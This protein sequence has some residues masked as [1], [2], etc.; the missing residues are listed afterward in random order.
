MA[1]T[2]W[3]LDPAHTN[4]N[5]RVKHLVIATVRGKFNQFSSTVTSE[6]ADLTT[7]KIEFTLDAASL[8]TGLSDRDNHLRSDD[9]F[10]SEKYP[11]IRFV[12][13]TIQKSGE[14]EYRLDGQLTIRDI[15]KP[16]SL[17]VEYGGQVVDPWGQT[18]AV[19]E[20]T[21]SIRRKEFGLRWDAL[22]EAGGAVVSDEVKIEVNVQYILQQQVA[23]EAASATA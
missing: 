10:N 5:F 3:Q 23:G 4:V 11:E 2:I 14:N 15:T 1:T 6:G 9:F 12:S 20:V 16:L 22:T 13:Q 17:R 21:G 19:F 7:A 18:R 8:D